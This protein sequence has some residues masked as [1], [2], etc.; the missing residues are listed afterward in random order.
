MTTPHLSV[1]MPVHNAQPWLKEAAQSIL[2]QSFVDFE[3][4]VLDDASNDDSLAMLRE[5]ATGD[6]RIRVL[7]SHRR[8]GPVES[9]N[10]VVENARAQIIARMDADDRAHSQRLEKQMGQFFT[11]R[12]AVLVGTLGETIDARGRRIR[13]ADYGRLLHSTELAPFPHSSVMFR[14]DAFVRA[15]GYR[16]GT[17]FWEDID[18]YLR[19][20]EQGRIL[21]LPEPLMAIRQTGRSTRFTEGHQKLHEAMDLMQRCLAAYRGGRDYA[22][23]LTANVGKQNSKLSPEAFLSGASSLLWAGR[24]PNVLGPMLG[25]ARLLPNRRHMMLLAWAVAADAAPK[26][27][28]FAL[29]ALLKWRNLRASRLLRDP[30][31]IE[32]QPAPARFR[33]GQMGK[34]RRIA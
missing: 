26:L 16:V 34:R 14:K 18:L 6:R 7:E 29:R 1:V 21:V 23:L 4:I 20:A 28:R 33:G 11:C 2:K 13:P 17:D 32:W 10:L 8:L 25:S 9:S 5:L 15:G 19:M 22:P 27:L 12:A 3:L 24:R 30:G 31:P